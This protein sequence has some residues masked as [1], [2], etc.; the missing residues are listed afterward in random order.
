MCFFNYFKEEWLYVNLLI[1]FQRNWLFLFVQQWHE[2]FVSIFSIIIVFEISAFIGF[3]YDLTLQISK[4]II[5]INE[6]IWTFFL[7]K[8]IKWCLLVL[9]WSFF[10]Y[11]YIHIFIMQ[12]TLF[13]FHKTISKKYKSFHWIIVDLY[14]INGHVILIH[15]IIW[16]PTFYHNIGKWHEMRIYLYRYEFDVNFII[17]LY[18]NDFL[19]SWRWNQ[20]MWKHFCKY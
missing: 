18:L 11:I 12:L 6:K 19:I 1:F 10:K 13:R 7:Y 15:L 14:H 8:T 5:L 3:L 2:N 4:F 17:V 16:I 9:N 20:W